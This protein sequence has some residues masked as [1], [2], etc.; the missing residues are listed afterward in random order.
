MSYS[1][2]DKVF[3]DAKL[4]EIREIKDNRIVEVSDGYF[5]HSGYDLTPDIF[6]D[7]PRTR[8]ISKRFDDLREEFHRIGNN[9]LNYPDVIGHLF[10][11]WRQECSSPE[12]EESQLEEFANA[13]RQALIT[14]RRMQYHGIYLLDSICRD[15]ER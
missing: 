11:I 6:P 1:V 3:C 13:V 14:A 10:G 4:Q 8:E 9:L 7:T 2:G 12:G 5:C 15:K